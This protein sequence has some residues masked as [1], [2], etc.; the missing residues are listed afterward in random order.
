MRFVLPGVITSAVAIF[1]PPMGWLVP[2]AIGLLVLGCVALVVYML[3]ERWGWHR[4][5][6][7][8]E[9]AQPGAQSDAA[10]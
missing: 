5:I 10:R 1:S 2:W 7:P 3:R 4:Y 6:L 8:L 9:N